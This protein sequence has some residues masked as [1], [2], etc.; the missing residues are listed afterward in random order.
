[1]KGT[2][3]MIPLSTKNHPEIGG[4]FNYIICDSDSFFRMNL[5]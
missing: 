2:N 4:V 1:M 3:P 5:I